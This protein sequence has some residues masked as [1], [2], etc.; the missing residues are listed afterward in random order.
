MKCVNSGNELI[1]DMFSDGV[2]F[3]CGTPVSDSI[4]AY[5]QEQMEKQQKA[6]EEEKLRKQEQRELQQKAIR[7]EKIKMQELY[8][9]HLLST[10]YS[11][12]TCSI[13]KYIG[14]VSGECVIGT[15]WLSTMESGIS[16]FLGVESTTY[17][18]KIKRAK[19][20]ALNDMVK[21][22]IAKGGNAI[23]GISYEII[24]LSRDMIGVSVNGTSVIVNMNK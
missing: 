4:E 21:E 20:V 24:S 15:G 13:I 14:I 16:D 11:F 8:V 9:K 17:S 2:C 12:E 19:K 7:E 6:I 23:I 5:E 22:S 18:D 10:G 1:E 3:K